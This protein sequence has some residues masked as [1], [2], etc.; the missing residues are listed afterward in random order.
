MKISYAARCVADRFAK[1]E[2]D[3]TGSGAAK[4]E[5]VIVT[6]MWCWDHTDWG[7]SVQIGNDRWESVNF[8]G[9]E[10]TLRKLILLKLN[11]CLITINENV[12]KTIKYVSTD[13]RGAFFLLG[14]P[15]IQAN[16]VD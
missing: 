6:E 14:S 1:K 8:V 10:I 15:Q 16:A 9:F 11:L 4:L 3:V 2:P 5:P 13:M 7:C 12:G